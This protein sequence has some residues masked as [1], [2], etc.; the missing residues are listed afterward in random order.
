[1][2]ILTA[3][4][5]AQRGMDDDELAEMLGID[6]KEVL[7]RCRR[8][9]FQGILIREEAAEG[10]IVNKLDGGSVGDGRLYFEDHVSINR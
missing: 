1:M 7:R 9:A 6:R 8:L 2:D 5:I 3:L 10:R 4:R